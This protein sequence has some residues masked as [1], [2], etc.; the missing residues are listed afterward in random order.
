MAS[1][2]EDDVED[3]SSYEDSFIDDGVNPTAVNTQS[4]S[5]RVDMMAIYR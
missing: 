1:G 4:G 5:G 3:G 2:D